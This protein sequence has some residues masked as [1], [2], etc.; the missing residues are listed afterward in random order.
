MV[1]HH[2]CS[3]PKS[4][5]AR[6]RSIGTQTVSEFLRAQLARLFLEAS[7]NGP[8][9][10][11]NG[12]SS[13][14][15]AAMSIHFKLTRPLLER[16]RDDLD[17]PH[18]F[19][20]ERMGFLFTRGGAGVNVSRIVIATDYV[21]VVDQ[22]YVDDPRVGARIGSA[23]IRSV[24]QRILDTKAGAFHVHLHSHKGRPSLS[25]VDQ[26]ELPRLLRSFRNVAPNEVH[27]ALIFSDDCGAGICLRPGE[28]NFD[29][30]IQIS[31]IGYP[32]GLFGKKN[33]KPAL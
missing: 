22:D 3:L 14:E 2:D 13:P 19:A 27:G 10:C 8:A 17:R 5:N 21:P 32:L 24:M 7:S 9:A 1:I 29:P 33:D 25:R 11:A 23:A 15:T 4:W 20:G 18:G 30:F 31:V 6:S 28:M 12:R 16:V 26:N